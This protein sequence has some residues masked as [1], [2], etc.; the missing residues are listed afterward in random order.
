V[1]GIAR[2][3]RRS[4]RRVGCALLASQPLTPDSLPFYAPN[5]T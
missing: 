2:S 3:P 5:K 1:G 4:S